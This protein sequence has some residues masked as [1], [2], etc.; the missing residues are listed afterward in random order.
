MRRVLALAAAVLLAGCSHSSTD[1]RPPARAVVL[2]SGLAST[3]PYTAP[4][5]ACTIGLPAGTDH[6]A[7]REHLLGKGYSVFTAPAM[8]GSGQVHDTTGYGA[9]A[10]CPAPLPA[11]RTIDSTG[12]IDLAGEHLARFID[13]LHTEKHIDEVDLVGH[14]MGGLFARAAIRTLKAEQSAV[15][16]RSLT[17]IGT[18]WQG[19]YLANFV[20]GGVKIGDCLGDPFCESQMTGYARDIAAVHVS[21]SAREL[22]QSYLTGPKGWNTFQAG[23]LEAVP[24]TLIGGNRF[25]RPGGAPAVW[26]NDGVVELRSALG[27]DVDDT[28]LPHRRCRI[29][30]DTHSD[31]VSMIAQ[32]PR[33]TALTW[34]P[35]VLDAVAEAIEGAATD[36]D[37]PARQGC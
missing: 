4:D 6:T 34:D 15:R 12:G 21:G 26:P 11:S 29:V 3:A 20:E 32:L 30:D 25:D 24:V 35:R 28:V 8:A 18:P 22:G 37:G 17:T 2:V 5:A 23:V 10:S 7:L 13:W 36:L 14:S 27:R 16:V 1:T 31:Y 9:F 19:S 33:A